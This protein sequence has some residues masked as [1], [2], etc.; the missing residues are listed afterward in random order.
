MMA[1][2]ERWVARQRRRQRV[3]IR[4][5]VLR[6]YRYGYR[7]SVGSFGDVW[8]I[9]CTAPDGTLDVITRENL[10]DAW[11]NLLQR[12]EGVHGV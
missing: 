12:Y 3:A 5:K 4:A 10:W 2:D 8:T 7:F 1:L 6:L 11:A 9:S